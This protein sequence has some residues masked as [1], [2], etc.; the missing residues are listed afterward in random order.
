LK[1]HPNPNAPGRYRHGFLS[2]G[3]DRSYSADMTEAYSALAS[4]E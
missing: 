4:G 3:S 1:Q 2:H